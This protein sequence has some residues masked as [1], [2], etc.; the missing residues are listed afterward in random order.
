MSKQLDFYFDFASPTTYLAHCRLKQ[1]SEQYGLQVNYKPMLLGGVFKAAQN[2]SPVTVPA[3]GSY[4][5]LVDLPSRSFEL[6]TSTVLISWSA[7]AKSRFV[8][9]VRQASAVGE[10]GFRCTARLTFSAS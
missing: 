6:V 2:S 7:D 1:L 8:R 9:M 3:K 10:V 4:M 5:M